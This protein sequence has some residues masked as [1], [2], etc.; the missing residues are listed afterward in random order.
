M[1]LGLPRFGGSPAL[2]LAG[3]G[4]DGRPARLC[5]R[6]ASGRAGRSCSPAAALEQRPSRRA[7]QP[8]EADQAP[9]LRPCRAGSAQ[10]APDPCR[11]T[12]IYTEAADEPN[13]HADLESSSGSQSF[14]SGGNKNAWSRSQGTK[15][16]MPDP[17]H[18]PQGLAP[19]SDRL[20]GHDPKIMP[21]PGA[22]RPAQR[23]VERL[24]R[25]PGVAG[26]VGSSC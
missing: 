1:E 14:M 9:G 18:P 20:L 26:G 5:C 15:V 23:F 11:M 2:P 16:A 22:Q 10:G 25:P 21:R 8:L 12:T 19:Q 4:R 24:A 13:F 6:L 7:G 17:S 3:R